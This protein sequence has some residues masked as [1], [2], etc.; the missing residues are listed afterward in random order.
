M[1]DCSSPIPLY[2]CVSCSRIWK[3]GSR[4]L[5]STCPR[6]S[7]DPLKEGSIV[8][9]RGRGN[10]VL[11]GRLMGRWFW[12][13]G[14]CLHFFFSFFFVLF[15]CRCYMDFED[16]P[17]M[18][19]VQSD[20]WICSWNVRFVKALHDLDHCCFFAF[21]PLILHIVVIRKGKTFD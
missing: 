14:F 9:S 15:G 16:L 2:R 19:F 3:L 20:I 13:D 18:D 8:V 21:F 7:I 5:F 12:R 1:R 10:M 6:R 4:V 11:L 17:Y